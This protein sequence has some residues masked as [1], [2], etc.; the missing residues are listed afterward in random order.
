VSKP[1][2]LVIEDNADT[3]VFLQNI[4]A[5]EFDVIATENAHTGI[6][7]AKEKRPDLILMDVVLPTMNGFDACSAIKSDPAVKHIP[8]IFLSVKN[9][10]TDII[11]GLNLGADDFVTKPFDYREL[12]ARMKA[13]LRER[14]LWMKEPKTVVHGE[15][16]L[17]LDNRDA[18]YSE[19]HIDLTE[20]EFDI[21]RLLLQRS[22]E[23]LSRDVLI[24][25]LWKDQKDKASA[26]TID[27][28]IRAIRRKIPEIKRHLISVYGSGYKYER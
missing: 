4:L 13:R 8:V 11:H 25:E 6:N 3:R 28:H 7:M 9:T 1:L 2:I 5:N 16:R 20:T 15:L 14:M 27:V 23:I 22:G 10:V 17:V 18:Y 24:E 26:R 19:K 21:L 12:L